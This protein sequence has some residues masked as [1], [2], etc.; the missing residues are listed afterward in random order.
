M[1]RYWINLAMGLKTGSEVRETGIRLQ[2]NGVE[3]SGIESLARSHSPDRH[4]KKE[5]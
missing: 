4:D 2:G 1:E 3:E 5:I